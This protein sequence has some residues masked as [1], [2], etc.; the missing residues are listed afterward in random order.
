MERRKDM[1]EDKRPTGRRYRKMDNIS[2]VFFSSDLRKQIFGNTG[3]QFFLFQK[4]WKNIVGEILA[5]ES[6]VIGW[7]GD[8]LIVSV[9][10]S[11][12]LQQLFMMT[13]EILA[14]LQKDE[15]GKYFKDIRFRAGPHKR[16]KTPST[17]VDV[18]NRQIEK[19]EKMYS[20]PLTEKERAWVDNW[21]EKHVSNEKIRP[22]FA[23][24]MAEAMKIRKGERA[25]GYHPCPVC[26]SLCPPERKI[27]IACERKLE[28]QK[29][30]KVILILKAN[31]HYTYQEVNKILPCDYSMYDEAR[32]ILIHRAK[33]NIFHKYGTAEEKRKLLSLLLHKPMKEITTEEAELALNKMPQKWWE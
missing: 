22:Q 9:S 32:E 18:V 11:A 28:K 31:P 23:D 16:E 33:E 29:K 2:N 24:M 13:R 19:E 15:V 25:S 5:S 27:C 10:N 30:N 26:G 1:D 21:V 4:R 3:F 20:L 7:K 17:T 12:V 14:R 6:W 8:I